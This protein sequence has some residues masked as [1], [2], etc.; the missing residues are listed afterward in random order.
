MNRRK[1]R[2]VVSKI[3]YHG[4]HKLK[5]WQK[6]FYNPPRKYMCE[7]RNSR[8]KAEVV[9][10]PSHFQFGMEFDISAYSFFVERVKV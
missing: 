5:W 7:E 6:F 8:R 2:K 4:E 1:F 10:V 9:R 3:K